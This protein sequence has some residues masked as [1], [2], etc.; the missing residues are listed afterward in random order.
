MTI[1]LPP[2]LETLIMKD[3]QRG[4]YESVSDFVA[5]AVQMLHAQEEWLTENRAEI[6][7]KIEEGYAAAK[8]G[9]MLSAEQVRLRMEEKKRVWLAEQP[10]P[11]AIETTETN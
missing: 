8:R 9:E 3:M 10:H 2:E 5:Q 4:P 1:E 11:I 6:E 7:A